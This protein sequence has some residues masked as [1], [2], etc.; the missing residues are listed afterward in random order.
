MPDIPLSSGFSVMVDDED[1]EYLAQ[2][3][4]S[5]GEYAYRSTNRAD[6]R[7]KRT[8]VLMHRIIVERM[9]GAPVP[10][11]MQIDHING[12]RLDNRRRNLRFATCRQNQ[13]NKVKQKQPTSSRYKGVGWKKSRRRWRAAINTPSGQFD[14]GL[15][16]SEEDAARAYDKA[17]REHFGEYA[18]LNFPDEANHER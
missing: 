7:E 13:H 1:Y 6:L 11:G 16:A 3:K 9:T 12:N 2:W 15:H 4:W 17:A 10:K 8:T 5:K 18:R 14:L